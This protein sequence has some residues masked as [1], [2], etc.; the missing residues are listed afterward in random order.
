[1]RSSETDHTQ[2]VAGWVADGGSSRR[3]PFLVGLGILFFSTLLFALGSSLIT[4]MAARCLQGAAAGF[5]YT[6]GLALLVDTVGGDQVGSWMGFTIS[7]MTLGLLLGPM[8]GG[9]IYEKSGYF[10][11]FAVAL[12]VIAF[13][14]VLP[15]LMIEKRSAQKWLESLSER[16]G[17]G[18]M[19]NQQHSD[20]VPWPTVC[21][22]NPEPQNDDSGSSS[23]VND[24]Q[25]PLR[26]GV[27]ERESHCTSQQ[28]RPGIAIRLVKRFPTTY[29]LISSQRLAAALYGGFVQVALICSFDSVLPLFVHRTFGWDSSAMGLIFLAISIPALAGSLAGALSD[30]LGTRVVVLGGFAISTTALALLSL[31]TDNSIH[32]KVLLC[33]LL[34]IISKPL[35]PSV[36]S[37]FIY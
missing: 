10:A 11:V 5:V 9:L 20:P 19:G 17:Y 31:I 24:E 33:A 3:A 1:M 28:S 4:L 18:T 27:D 32:Q 6:V 34:A 15:L 14:F 35:F 21:T 30:R 25:R 16:N 36:E 7:G 23:D 13:D 8:L 29:A 37:S 26:N 2:A 12:A 22:V